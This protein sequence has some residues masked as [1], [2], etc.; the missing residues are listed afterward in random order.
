MELVFVVFCDDGAVRITDGSREW[1]TF[2]GISFPT[3]GARI[4]ALQGT[5]D[6]REKRE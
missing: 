3:E 6:P 1:V 5:N 2:D 4:P